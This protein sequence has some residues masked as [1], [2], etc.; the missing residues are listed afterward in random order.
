LAEKLSSAYRLQLQEI[1]LQPSDG[2]KFEVLADDSLLFSKKATGR[3]PEA[4]EVEKLVG[5]S[6]VKN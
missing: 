4:E 5:A 3:F 6:L 1:I 2:G